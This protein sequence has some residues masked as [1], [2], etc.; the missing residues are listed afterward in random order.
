MSL[1][2]LGSLQTSKRGETKST[3]TRHDMFVEKFSSMP[4]IAKL[5]PLFKSSSPLELTGNVS[6]KKSLE[7]YVFCL[8]GCLSGTHLLHYFIHSI[9]S[10]VISSLK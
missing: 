8:G 5:G 2:F 10:S 3:A 1:K 4:E 9:Q 7:K 6:F